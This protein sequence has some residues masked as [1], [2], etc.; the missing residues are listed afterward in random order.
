MDYGIQREDEVRKI[1]L[2]Q[3]RY[4]AH[5]DLTW[6]I[7]LNSDSLVPNMRINPSNLQNT[8]MGINYK[9]MESR[10]NSF[11]KLIWGI[12]ISVQMRT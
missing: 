2:P 12:F 5:E 10:I 11:V 8:V 6:N 3:G 7:R 4:S 1:S 9:P